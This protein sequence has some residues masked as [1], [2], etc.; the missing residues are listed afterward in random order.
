MFAAVKPAVVVLNAV[1]KLV[2]NVCISPAPSAAKP[3]PIGII[4]PSK[5]H[6]APTFATISTNSNDLDILNSCSSIKLLAIVSRVFLLYKFLSNLAIEP[7]SYLSL[8][9]KL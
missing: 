8:F 1:V 9:V 6:A 4:V 2:V 7:N 5:P 3:G